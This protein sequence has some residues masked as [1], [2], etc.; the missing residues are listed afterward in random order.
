MTF[1]V[2]RILNTI[3]EYDTNE[4]AQIETFTIAYKS[5]GNGNYL[6]LVIS[7]QF[8]KPPLFIL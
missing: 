4:N 5:I 7:K 2:V 3:N 6:S 8:D 1:E